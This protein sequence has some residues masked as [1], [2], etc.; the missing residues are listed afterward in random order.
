MNNDIW[1]WQVDKKTRANR[2]FAAMFPVFHREVISDSDK[3][4]RALP[5]LVEELSDIDSLAKA[6]SAIRKTLSSVLSGAKFTSEQYEVAGQ[7]LFDWLQTRRIPRSEYFERILLAL[8]SEYQ[9]PAN[10][11][12]PG[13]SQRRILESAGILIRGDTLD[14]DADIGIL[15]E[16][17]RTFSRLIKEGYATYHD[18]WVKYMPTK[19]AIDEVRSGNRESLSQTGRVRI[20]F[21][22]A[23]PTDSSR[24]RLGEEIREIQEK[25][26]LA[27]LREQF[28]LHQRMSVRPS[29]FSQALLDVQ[30][31]VVHF[32]GH[33]TA[34]GSL[35]FENQN[36]ETHPIEPNALAALF[37]QFASQVYCVVLNACYSMN[38]ANAIAKH[39]RYVIGMN[40]AIGDKAAI[41]FAIGFYQ[42]LGGGRTIEEAYKLGCVQ[43]QLQNIP[44][45]LTPVIISKELLR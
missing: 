30:P 41:A 18:G 45:N 42:A 14:P 37:E 36:G 28:E 23:D 26:Q 13:V 22:S 44:E 27:K 20:L 34:Y 2:L 38:Q 31:H 10:D 21:L 3:F 43:I 6:V 5:R 39:I 35:C 16:V 40:Q 33:G 19:K 9:Q 1:Y 32:S 25:L 4:Y 17:D 8:V 24:L 29:D 12:G 11:P 7:R 15:D